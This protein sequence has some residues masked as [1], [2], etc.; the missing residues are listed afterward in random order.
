MLFPGCVDRAS[1]ITYHF[2]WDGQGE[3]VAQGVMYRI[4]GEGK[5]RQEDSKTL[6][7]TVIGS[8]SF[9]YTP[10]ESIIMVRAL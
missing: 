8:T 4:W 2:H 5:K 6:L 3:L 7:F 9:P 1:D 10:F